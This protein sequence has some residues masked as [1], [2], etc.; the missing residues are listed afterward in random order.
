VR[1]RSAIVSCNKTTP[2]L[3]S[4]D[5]ITIR[6]NNSYSNLSELLYLLLKQ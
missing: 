3:C 2:L 4:G 5:E 1:R 6:A